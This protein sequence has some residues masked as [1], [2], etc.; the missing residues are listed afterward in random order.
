ME[1]LYNIVDNLRNDVHRLYWFIV[2]LVHMTTLLFSANS[3]NRRI[4]TYLS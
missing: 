1:I 4:E 2:S 3:D